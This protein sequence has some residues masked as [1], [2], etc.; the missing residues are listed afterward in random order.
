MLAVREFVARRFCLTEINNSSHKL[1]F[2]F[3]KIACCANE[4]LGV[5]KI[6]ILFTTPNIKD[7]MRHNGPRWSVALVNR[8]KRLSHVNTESAFYVLSSLSF[9]E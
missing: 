8:E 6:I 1:D 3:W 9:S 4:I 5:V 2:F 7:E